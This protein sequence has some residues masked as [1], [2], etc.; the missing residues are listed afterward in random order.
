MPWRVSISFS[1]S[2]LSPPRFRIE[3]KP[4]NEVGWLVEFGTGIEKRNIPERVM[5]YKPYSR[6][7]VNL[8]AKQRNQA[9][10]RSR[11][12][13]VFTEYLRYIVMHFLDK[14]QRVRESNDLEGLKALFLC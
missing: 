14:L 9:S 8:I 11:K 10:L 1:G 3:E 13:A 5:K 4:G 12:T 6:E 7:K 2:S